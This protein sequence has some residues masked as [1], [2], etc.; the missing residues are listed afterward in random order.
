MEYSCMR[1][2]SLAANVP[3]VRS[4]VS[5]F[6]EAIKEVLATSQGASWDLTDYFAVIEHGK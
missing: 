6:A 3:N 4:R 5:A 2:K 1:F